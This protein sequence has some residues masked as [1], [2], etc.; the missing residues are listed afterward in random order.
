MRCSTPPNS[1]AV[2]CGT[3]PKPMLRSGVRRTPWPECS[4]QVTAEYDVPLMVTRGYPSISY[5][6]EAAEAI[7]ANGKPAH[8]YYFGD[9]DPSGV[10][11]PRTVENRIRE[12]VSGQVDIYFEVAA[13]TSDQIAKFDLPTRPTK[14]TDT[15]S[16]NFA[17]QSVE[18]DAIPPTEL[19]QLVR[20]RIEQ[21]VD[22]G[23]LDT[24]KVAE[25]SERELLY[26][27]ACEVEEGAL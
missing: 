4:I 19:R 15:R 26:Q 7:V 3:I 20:D 9:H 16:K 12:Y 2:R 22:H 17:G 8:L 10:D 27:W 25:Q 1:T 5:L 24:L 13:V 21:H 23:Q 14:K 18:L 11:I 6:Y